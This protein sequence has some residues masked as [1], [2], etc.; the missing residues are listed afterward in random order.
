MEQLVN[1]ILAVIPDASSDWIRQQVTLQLAVDPVPYH[2]QVRILDSAFTYGYVKSAQP[3]N[4]VPQPPAAPAAVSQTSTAKKR[5]APDQNPGPSKHPPKKRVAPRFDYTQLER[6]GQQGGD[7]YYRELSIKYLCAKLGKL[8]VHYVRHR[9]NQTN[10]LVPTYL[11]LSEELAT[12]TAKCELLKKKRHSMGPYQTPYTTSTLFTAE[13]KALDAFIGN[14]SPPPDPATAGAGPPVAGPSNAAPPRAVA[15]PRDAALP[16]VIAP[17]K[18][19]VIS[20]AAAPSAPAARPQPQGQPVHPRRPA[21]PPRKPA[22][23]PRP[24]ETTKMECGCCFGDTDIPEMTQCAEG[25]LF[26]AN[27]TKQNAET[28]VGDRNPNVLFV[29]IAFA[30]LSW[31]DLRYSRCMDQSGCRAPFPDDQLRRVL[32]AN[33]LDL[34]DRLRQAK[35]LEAAK[36]GGLEHCPFCDFAC[37]IV[38]DGRTFLC[39]KPTCMVVSCRKCRRKDHAPKTCEQMDYEEKASKGEHEIA[40]AMTRALIR[41]CPKCNTPFMKEAGCNKMNCPKCG[42]ISCYICRKEISK[43][44]PYIHFDQQPDAYHLTPAKGRCRLW[45]IDRA[46]RT[47]GSPTRAHNEEVSRAEREARARIAAAASGSNGR[48]PAPQFQRA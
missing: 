47:G 2:A 15:A 30:P 28:A 37:I 46:G 22:T 7:P 12:G 23:P 38:D 32:S 20:R 14:A 25:H 4:P 24:V 3:S 42:T 33:T 43:L 27:C 6:P 41:D 10:R 35:E 39:Q 36:L 40:E 16:K 29:S 5:K 17:P 31:K 45:D 1:D 21:P 18:P 48:I 13:R 9:F 26:C 44:S 34:L 19:A 8:P 11:A